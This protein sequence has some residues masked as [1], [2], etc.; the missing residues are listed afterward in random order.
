M[1]FIQ[2]KHQGLILVTE[3]F[4][5]PWWPQKSTAFRLVIFFGLSGL[6]EGVLEIF[7]DMSWGSTPGYGWCEYRRIAVWPEGK[8]C[9]VGLLGIHL[10]WDSVGKVDMSFR[11]SGSLNRLNEREDLVAL[12]KKYSVPKVRG[13]NRQH[14]AVA[15]EILKDGLSRLAKCR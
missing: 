2:R 15:A 5:L 11:C 10:D 12:A 14:L 13:A 6:L 3:S 1:K 4:V 7:E 8:H 9:K